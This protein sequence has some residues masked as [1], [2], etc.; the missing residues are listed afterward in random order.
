MTKVYRTF[1]QWQQVPL[2]RPHGSRAV[3]SANLCLYL[4]AEYTAAVGTAWSLFGLPRKGQAALHDFQ[5][6]FTVLEYGRSFSHCAVF[7]AEN[8]C[9]CVHSAPPPPLITP[10]QQSPAI[11]SLLHIPNVLS[12]WIPGIFNNSDSVAEVSVPRGFQ[13]SAYRCHPLAYVNQPKALF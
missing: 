12:D 7:E 6:T 10:C 5:K 4:S 8:T 13:L 3:T 2:I 9:W 1:C 11:R